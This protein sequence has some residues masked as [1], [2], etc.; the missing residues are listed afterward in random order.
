MEVTDTRATERL[1]W[2]QRLESDGLLRQERSCHRTT[3]RWQAAMA[4]AALQLITSGDD[5][6]DLRVP[7]VLALI[8]L[9]GE[10]LSTDEI[11]QCVE[12]IAPIEAAELDPS[13]RLSSAMHRPPQ[14]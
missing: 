9:Y 4:R 6:N 1:E 3:R 8:E 10:R 7:I 2:L 12:I 13:G 11:V 14:S 5:S